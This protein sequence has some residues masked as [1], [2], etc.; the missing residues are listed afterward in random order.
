MSW[1]ELQ[2]EPAFGF[3]VVGLI[4]VFGPLLAE[5]AR[6]PGVLG[7]LVLGALIGP[8]M[9]ELLPNFGTLQ[10]VGDIG[11]LYLIFL[12]GLQLDLDAFRDNWRTSAGFGGLTSIIPMVLGTWA[13]HAAGLDI[14]AAVLVGS[15]WAS[16]TLIAYPIISQYGLTKNR[17]VSAIV[18]AS[19]IT[20]TVSLV[21]L[22]L[23]VGSETGDV[24][25]VRL[26]IELAVGF[27][28]LAV[29]CFVAAPLVA[30]WFFAGL[31]QE[32]TLRFMLVLV[33]LTSAAVV[34]D[35]VG[36]EPLIGAFFV[37]VGLN[38]LVPN[39][40]PLMSVTEFYGN[41]FFVPAFLVSVGLLFDPHVMVRPTTLKLA[42]GFTAALIVGKALA[43]I[44][45]GRIFRLER[46]ETGLMFS[47]SVAQ[48]AATLAATIVGLQAGLYGE[49]VVNA[50]MVVVSISLIITSA[51][52][53]RFAKRVTPPTEDRPPLGAT[54]LI[55]V[56]RDPGSL[57]PVIELAD[58]I[59]SARAGVI[60]PVVIGTSTDMPAVQ[61]VRAAADEA[62]HILLALG[63]DAGTIMRLDRSIAVGV[64]RVA[65]ESGG[66]LL[67]LD[68]PATRGLRTI[69]FG[70]TITEIIAETALPTAA[71][72]LQDE[73][74]HRVILVV[75]SS[76]LLPARA[77]SVAV[78]AEL[79]AELSDRERPLFVGPVSPDRVCELGVE[80]PEQAVHVEPSGGT[81]SEFL[82]EHTRPGDLVIAPVIRTPHRWLLDLHASGRSIIAMSH[83]PATETKLSGSSLSFPVGGSIAPG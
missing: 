83:N 71:V 65:I 54:V 30:R 51:G 15:F 74:W 14:K 40:S 8:N 61:A 70:R 37:G 76:D 23:I 60:H 1:S 66:S 4:I 62:D 26:V 20:D 38:R 25:G 2:V 69:L 42:I 47:V 33:S 21:I 11:V 57:R 31:G 28:L 36:V 55:P 52:T 3:T 58:R 53:E 59:A 49:N 10:A 46:A 81:L 34:A 64:Q 80:L 79:A 6:L 72:A 50:V 45:T 68:W 82:A 73:P 48:A 18:G 43:A 7:L 35:V 12:S 9:L 24:G 29:Y 27:L 75:R 16:F 22:A 32:R 77:P 19:S 17:A 44:A 63:R 56:D 13:A 67:L 5:R 39:A 41:A 78:A